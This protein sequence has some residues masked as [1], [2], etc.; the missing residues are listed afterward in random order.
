M[1]GDGPVDTFGCP[2]PNFADFDGDGDL[3]LLCG[4]FLDGFTYFENT[5]TRTAP[6]LCRRPPCPGAPTG[7]TAGD[8]SG[9]DRAD[10]LRLGPRRRPGSRRRRR[11]R[12]RGAG[13]EHRRAGTTTARRR[14]LAP[15]YFQQQAELLKCGALAT[16]VGFDWDG[17]GDTDIVSGNTAGY[18]EW[19]ENLSGPG[20]A[21][22]QVGRAGAARRRRQDVS[23]DG[24][25]QRQHPRTLRSQVGLHHAVGGR[26]GPA[27]ACP[28]SCSI[29]SGAASSG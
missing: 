22:A 5:G 14:F 13:R 15:H 29:R 2:T 23:R 24:R 21:A 3:D 6:T 1:A 10:R 12:P 8:G 27:T 20:V 11:R 19:F 18:I 28:T 16:P 9:N 26:L 4:E 25:P 7:R 17:D